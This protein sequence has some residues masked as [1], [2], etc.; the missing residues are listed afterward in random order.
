M[1]DNRTRID[2]LKGMV[3]DTRCYSKLLDAIYECIGN[4]AYEYAEEF[5]A[6]EA[7]MMVVAQEMVFDNTYEDD[8]LE[9]MLK[10]EEE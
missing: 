3:K 9:E 10:E 7:E 6:T 8:T 2:E 5:E 4:F 1:A